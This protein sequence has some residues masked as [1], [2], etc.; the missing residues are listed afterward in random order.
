MKMATKREDIG[1]LVE[2]TMKNRDI[3]SNTPEKFTPPPKRQVQIRFDPGDYETLQMI[4]HNKG[5]TAAA[6]IREAVKGIIKR[7]AMG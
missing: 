5:S 6:L 3:T 4:A 2:K 1:N 7:E